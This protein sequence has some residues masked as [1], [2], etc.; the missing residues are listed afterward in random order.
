[1]LSEYL[2]KVDQAVFWRAERGAHHRT[3]VP[4]VSI[5]SAEIVFKGD[6]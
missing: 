5:G 4:A 3:S 6:G 1:M 2:N